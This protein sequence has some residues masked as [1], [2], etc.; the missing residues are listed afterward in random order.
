MISKMLRSKLERDC[1]NLWASLIDLWLKFWGDSVTCSNSWIKSQIS[2]KK[3]YSDKTMSAM[4]Y[5]SIIF[6]RTTGRSRNSF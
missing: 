4:E 3:K 2:Q 1:K 5:A 6:L